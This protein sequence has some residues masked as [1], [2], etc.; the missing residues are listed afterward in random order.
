MVSALLAFD[1]VYI[2]PRWCCE[3]SSHLMEGLESSI[4]IS[5][6][7]NGFLLSSLPRVASGAVHRDAGG[8]CMKQAY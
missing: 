4:H 8:G 5:H 6:S 3:V 1:C 2:C 7:S